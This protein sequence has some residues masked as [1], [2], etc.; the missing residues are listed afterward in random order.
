MNW[1][2]L[3]AI[4]CLAGAVSCPAEE[5]TAKLVFDKQLKSMEVEFVPL[6][7]AMPAGKFDFAPSDGAF[8]GVRTFA[9]QAK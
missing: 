2:V 1:I 7:E 5:Q 4:T 3:I 8:Q 9:M 6:V